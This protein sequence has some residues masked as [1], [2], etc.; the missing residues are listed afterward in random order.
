MLTRNAYLTREQFL[1][2]ASV[3]V[4]LVFMVGWIG[5]LGYGLLA[6]MGY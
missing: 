5:L 6:I 3:F 1:P 4:G 2:L